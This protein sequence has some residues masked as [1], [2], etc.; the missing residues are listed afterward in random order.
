MGSRVCDL[1][2]F[3]YSMASSGID[4]IKEDHS[5]ATQV[6]HP[7]DDRVP[8]LAEAVQRGA[9]ARGGPSV[10]LPALNVPFDRIGPAIEL[11]LSAGAGGVLVLPGL[12]GYDTMRWVAENTPDDFVVQ[13]HPAFL[14]SYVSS[15]HGGIAH[16]VMFGLLPRLAG[17]DMSIFP[18]FGGR[19]SFSPDTCLEV[20]ERCR[21][22]LGSISPIWPAPAGGMT[23]DR[24]QPMI[25]FYGPDTALLIGG[26]LYRGAIEDRVKEMR[27][28]ALE[29]N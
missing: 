10:F 1:A 7:F 12:T 6:F 22:P 29:G 17:A 15:P 2:R 4:L 26:G 16:D 20:A 18:N 25:E 3:A 5:F 8:V 24:V 9:E 11:A 13:A 28:T 23:V 14:G 27:M 19:F 21:A